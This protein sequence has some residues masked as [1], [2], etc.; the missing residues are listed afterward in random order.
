MSYYLT[1]IGFWVSSIED[2]SPA[3]NIII[4]EDG[5]DIE[6]IKTS[7]LNTDSTAPDPRTLGIDSKATT[8]G[9]G[10]RWS[11]CWYDA[12]AKGEGDEWRG[13][14]DTDAAQQTKAEAAAFNTV[15]VAPKSS[16]IKSGNMCREPGAVDGSGDVH[17]QPNGHTTPEGDRLMLQRWKRQSAA[18]D[19][20]YL[21]RI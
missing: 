4:S 16:P 10:Y 2:S 19:P 20:W 18:E 13:E 1:A 7:R 8:A 17:T 21:G 11:G 12:V 5:D 6:P 15:E 14:D 3:H 9:Y